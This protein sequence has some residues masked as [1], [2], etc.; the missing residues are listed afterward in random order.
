ITIQD[1]GTRILP[2]GEHYLKSPHEM[3]RLFR[4][5]PEA[6]ARTEEVVEKV[7]SFSLD[8]L[9]YEY[10]EITND[11]GSSQL[12]ELVSRVFIGAA[13]RFPEGIPPSVER[14]LEEEIHLIQELR[15]EKYFLT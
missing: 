15:Y 3:Y 6:V 5:I 8:Q 9:W 10:P 2:H 7:S 12:E 4:E 13:E 14:A 1:V 11:S